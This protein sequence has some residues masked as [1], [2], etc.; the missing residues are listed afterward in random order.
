MSYRDYYAERWGQRALAE[1][2][3]LLRAAPV[4]RQQLSRGL[5]LR[6]SR[7]RG[8]GV[9]HPEGEGRRPLLPGFAAPC[10]CHRLDVVCLHS[11]RLLR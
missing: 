7:K 2:Q 6:R 5:E 9:P 3:P 11:A 4:S 10:L 8:L 1:H